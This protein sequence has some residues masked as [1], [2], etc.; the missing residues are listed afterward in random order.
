MEPFWK[1]SLE[2]STQT[3]LDAVS[4]SPGLQTFSSCQDGCL[5]A[6]A[7]FIFGGTPASCTD[8]DVSPASAT[9]W[10]EANTIA[11]QSCECLTTTLLQSAALLAHMPSF[12]LASCNGARAEAML[13]LFDACKRASQTSCTKCKQPRH[14]RRQIWLSYCVAPFIPFCNM[15]L[16]TQ[17][18]Q[19]QAE[20]FAASVWPFALLDLLISLK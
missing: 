7:R 1:S 8:A 3:A 14:S 20:Q 6:V 16:T 17:S 18:S 4:D 11:P 9:S 15:Q 13:D 5:A 10:P 19:K 12:I 2:T